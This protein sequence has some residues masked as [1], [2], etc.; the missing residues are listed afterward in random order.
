MSNKSGVNITTRDKLLRAWQNSMEM[1]RDFE[2]YSKEIADDKQ[3]RDIFRE[4]AEEEG[5]HAAKFR[6]MLLERQDG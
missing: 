5:L 6:E 3:V 1:V 4:Y 2:T